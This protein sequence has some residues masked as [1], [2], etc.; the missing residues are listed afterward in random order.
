MLFELVQFSQLK[1][2]VKWL[3]HVAI[4]VLADRVNR[5]KRA[6]HYPV[7]ITARVKVKTQFP[8]KKL[9]GHPLELTH[10]F[11]KNTNMPRP[12]ATPEQKTEV[13]RILRKCAA[14]IYNR[15]GQ[16]GL[17]VRA[18][19]KEAKVSVGTIYTYFG[20]LQG[21]MESLW[22]GPVERVADELGS[23]SKQIKDP[24]ERI[25]SLMQVYLKFANDNA[26]M[27]RGVFLYVRPVERPRNELEPAEKAVFPALLEAAISDGQAQ[28]K[29]KACDAA[30]LAM[31]LWG[32][33]HGCLALPNNF[34]RLEF[35]NPDK[36]SEGV[37]DV[38]VSALVV[39]AA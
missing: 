26:E 29:I 37:I 31:M 33:L 6:E 23:I 5:L 18:I 38:L 11:C 9:C 35:R 24:V 14:E 10:S 39:K 4:G 17:S 19:A 12:E 27:Y 34:G 21:L 8:L 22:S 13:R 25:R 7:P 36:V 1:H 32:S 30:D 20:S 3:V 28:K 16:A 15:E 2:I